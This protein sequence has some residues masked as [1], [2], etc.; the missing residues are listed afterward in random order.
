MPSRRRHAAYAL[1][2]LLIA[3]G[4]LGILL[5]PSAGVA[6]G[7]ETRSFMVNDVREQSWGAS[8]ITFEIKVS[9][10]QNRRGLYFMHGLIAASTV[11]LFAG[12]HLLATLRAKAF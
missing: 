2:L 1:A 4:A 6:G 12:V 3:A 10:I 9:Y 7:R 8:I 5:S 11:T